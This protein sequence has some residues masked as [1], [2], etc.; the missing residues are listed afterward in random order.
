M[1][2]WHAAGNRV[3]GRYFFALAALLYMRP[4]C[5]VFSGTSWATRVNLNRPLLGGLGSQAATAVGLVLFLAGGGD[6][7]RRLC[8]W[9]PAWVKALFRAC[10][11]LTL[12]VAVSHNSGRNFNVHTTLS[13]LLPASLGPAPRFAANVVAS[14]AVALVLWV[15]VQYSAPAAVRR[16]GGGCF[17]SRGLGCWTSCRVCGTWGSAS[18]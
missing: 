3:P 12:G 17:G 7:R 4:D 13:W 10:S 6:L 2:R 5:E 1:L 9:W 18:S 16:C 11:R 8:S 15:T 14:Y